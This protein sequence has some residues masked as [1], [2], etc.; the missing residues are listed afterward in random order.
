MR[1]VRAL[2]ILAFAFL[3]TTSCAD[4]KI[5]CYTS[6]SYQATK[7][8]RSCKLWQP[9]WSPEVYFEVTH[10]HCLK[11]PMVNVFI[12]NFHGVDEINIDF[13]RKSSSWKGQSFAG[14]TYLIIL[15]FNEFNIDG[16]PGQLHVKFIFFPIFGALFSQHLLTAVFNTDDKSDCIWA[17]TL[18]LHDEV[19][20][21]IG[22]CGGFALILV[23]V[24]CFR[25]HKMRNNYQR[26]QPS[27]KVHL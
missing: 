15:K 6:A 17:E 23:A 8:E 2:S 11:E 16:S 22:L 4:S 3:I 14:K 13:N 5:E 19:F 10:K 25:N 20:L 18:E 1:F 7:G 21:G 24:F 26:P 12:R 27:G 9:N